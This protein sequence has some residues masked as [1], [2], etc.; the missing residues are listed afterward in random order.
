LQ[1]PGRDI[2]LLSNRKCKRMI[3]TTELAASPI[4]QPYVRCFSF[5]EFDTKEG[6]LSKPVPAIHEAYITFILNT[7][8]TT[9]QKTPDPSVTDQTLSFE[10]DLKADVFVLG[11]QTEFKGV[12]AFKGRIRLFSIQ[13]RANGF[14]KIFAIPGSVIT[15]GMIDASSVYKE[16]ISRLQLQ[17]QEAKSTVEM[18]NQTEKF[19]IGYLLKSNV[20]DGYNSV[21]AA[22]QLVFKH[23]GNI[24]VDRLAFFANMSLKTFERNFVTE[25]GVPPKLFSRI[26]RFNYALSLIMKNSYKN[27]SSVA[28]AC[29]YFDQMHL[30]KDFKTFAGD[31]PSAF[32]KHT[33]PPEERFLQSVD[34]Y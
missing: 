4:L 28:N 7:T 30:I 23:A 15:N 22:A 32:L 19:L 17:L 24:P 13:F 9:F 31:V 26:V 33:P 25:V 3:T 1:F 20:K 34:F 21:Q 11:L 12:V 2:N 10:N 27:W 8:K 18:V 14:Y 5:R 16:N 6:V 29:G